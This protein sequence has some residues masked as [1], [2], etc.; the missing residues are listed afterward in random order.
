MRGCS[1][2]IGETSKNGD[3]QSQPSDTSF[4]IV[5]IGLT[6]EGEICGPQTWVDMGP[7]TC[8]HSDLSE[9]LCPIAQAWLAQKPKS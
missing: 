5:A 1:F 2:V 7:V 6:Q 4:R 8:N 3:F 9:E